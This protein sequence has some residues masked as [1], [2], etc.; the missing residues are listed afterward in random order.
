MELIMRGLTILA[1]LSIVIEITLLHVPSIASFR[2][3]WMAN[4][5]VT[6]N[7]SAHYVRLFRLG[8]WAKTLL[9]LPPLVIVY[10]VFLYPIVLIVF[11]MSAPFGVLF[12]PGAASHVLA[13]L[14]IVAGRTLTLGSVLA[15]R[16]K[17]AGQASSALQTSGPFRWSRNPGLLGMYLM[18]LGFLAVLPTPEFLAGV[19]VYFFYMDFKVRMEEDFLHN[20]FG[21]RFEAYRART[22][23]YLA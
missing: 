2:S 5:D 21:E 13:I 12:E 7:Y 3:I 9:F 11:D 4:E 10:A 6:A 17:Q 15:M 20:R 18:F 19:L 16:S 14:L 1:Y 8:R 22:G 23:R